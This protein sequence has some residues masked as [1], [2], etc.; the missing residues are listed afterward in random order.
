MTGDKATTPFVVCPYDHSIQTRCSFVGPHT[1]G[2]Q[3]RE[4]AATLAM[5]RLLPSATTEVIV[6]KGKEFFFEP[7]GRRFNPTHKDLI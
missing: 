2:E 3:G 4:T 7:K 6:G 5:E 1:T